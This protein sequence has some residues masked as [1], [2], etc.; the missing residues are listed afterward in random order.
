M[1]LHAADRQGLVLDHHRDAVFG[2]RGHRQHLGHA[3]TLDIER[4]VAAD[5]DLVRQ[6][7]HQPAAAHLHARGTAMRGLGELA[8]LTAEIFADRLHAEADA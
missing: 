1:E 7:M 4:V 3:V 6:I 8:E 5:H 2:G